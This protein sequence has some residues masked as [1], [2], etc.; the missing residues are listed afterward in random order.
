MVSKEISA[1]SSADTAGQV[2]LYRPKKRLT[3]VEFLVKYKYLNL[4]ALPC[5]LYFVL[6]KYVPM[7]GLIIAFE[8]YKGT[9]GF[10]GMFTADW[11][12][13]LQ[14]KRFFTSIYFGRLLRNTLL[15][16]TYRLIFS[17]PAP[18]ILAIL[19]NEVNNLTFKKIVQTITYMPHFLSW[20]VV[21]GLIIVLLSPSYGPICAIMTF[22][23]LD[24]IYFV[25]DSRFFRSLIVLSEIW[26]SVGWGTIVYLAAITGID[27][28][29]Y[30][31]ATIDGASR[32]QKIVYIT[33]PSIREIIAILFILQVGRILNENFEQS[34]NLYNPSV[35]DVSDVFETYVYRAGIMETQ[36]SYS[37]AVGLFKSVVSLVLVVMSNFVAK[38]LGSEGLW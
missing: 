36:Y 6:F 5:V 26:K 18:I 4:L 31:A 14:F 13:F 34:F 30:E 32:W 8:N 2:Y 21:A 19:I 28:E 33:V 38:L 25:S 16:S 10:I 15:I 17:F 37:A 29:I 35:Y 1:G 24:P 9:G 12:G 23:G 11:V 7:Y 20:V 3:F 27:Q 22:L